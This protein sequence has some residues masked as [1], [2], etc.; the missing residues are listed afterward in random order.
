MIMEA[1]CDE[2]FDQDFG[3]SGLATE[4]V[5]AIG[6]LLG[7]LH[8]LDTRVVESAANAARKLVERNVEQCGM[9][10]VELDQLWRERGGFARL[11]LW[12]W[13]SP[14][15]SISDFAILSLERSL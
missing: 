15:P 6:S 11:I 2:G 4:E 8:L 5:Q 14:F 13:M 10:R 7:R 9:S 1:T 3:G 12:W